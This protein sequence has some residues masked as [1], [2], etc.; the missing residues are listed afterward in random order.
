MSGKMSRPVEP[1]TYQCP[2]CGATTQIQRL[3]HRK[4]AP[5]HLKWMWCVRCEETTNHEL[6]GPQV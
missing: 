4:K 6:V 5:G 3:S 1:E 2:D